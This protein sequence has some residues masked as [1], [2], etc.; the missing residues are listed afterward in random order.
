M[1]L[2]QVTTEAGVLTSFQG[3]L[4]LRWQSEILSDLSGRRK[5]AVLEIA[6]LMAEREVLGLPL[7]AVED[8]LPEIEALAAAGF[9]RFDEGA[10]RVEFRHQTL[11]EFIRARSFLDEA[12]SLTD[13]VLR[14]Q[15][16]LRIRP[17]LWHAL[18]FFRKTSPEDYQAELDRLWN[19]DLR[20]HLRM[21]VIELIGRQDAPLPAEVELVS[22]SLDDLWFRP[23]FINA[24]VGSPGWFDLLAG[25]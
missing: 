12:G 14:N 19:S 15:A 8:W 9:L 18:A 11:Y 25:G 1:G 6:R 2:L 4:Q 5:R 17:Q 13:A 10:G 7:A 16:S 21:L 3:M 23:R 22:R 24:C 20:P